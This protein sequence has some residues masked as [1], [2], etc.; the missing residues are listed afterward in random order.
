MQVNIE[1]IG[2]RECIR[3]VITDLTA[4]HRNFKKHASNEDPFLT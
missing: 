3:C 2:R 1:V 4:G